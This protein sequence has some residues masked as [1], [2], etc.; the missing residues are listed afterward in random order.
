[1]FKPKF[2]HFILTLFNVPQELLFSV[3]IKKGSAIDPLDEGYLHKK[4]KL[5]DDFCYPSVRGQIN[6]DFKWLVFFDSRTPTIFKNKIVEY[7]EWENFIPVYVEKDDDLKKILNETIS[8]NLSQSA[9]FLI[10][11]NLDNDDAI[12]KSFVNTVQENFRGQSFMFISLVY[13]YEYEI[14]KNEL[15]LREYMPNPFVSLI[16]KTDDFKTV[17]LQK[18]SVLEREI[19]PEFKNYIVTKPAWLQTIHDFNIFN[20]YDINSIW[21]PIGRLGGDFALNIDLQKMNAASRFKEIWY[22]IYQLCISKRDNDAGVK[23]IRKI[24]GILSPSLLRGIYDLRKVK[25]RRGK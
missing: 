12:S 16:E 22:H 10:T 9:E 24:I 23:R 1:M 8:R 21:Q 18:H 19:K 6:K 14:R 13:G 25:S 3:E 20:K 4:F 11:T 7:Q 2:T 5:F 15:R 17:W